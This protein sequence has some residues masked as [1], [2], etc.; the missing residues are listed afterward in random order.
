MNLN[1]GE[2]GRGG[3]KGLSRSGGSWVTGCG[4][5]TA[6]VSFHP[7]QEGYDELGHGWWPWQTCWNQ[8]SFTPGSSETRVPHP[9][10]VKWL[11]G[12]LPPNRK[13]LEELCSF[14][15][16]SASTFPHVHL[17]QR[18]SDSSG[19]SLWKHFPPPALNHV[20]FFSKSCLFLF[21]H[22]FSTLQWT[23]CWLFSHQP[24]TSSWIYGSKRENQNDACFSFCVV[25]EC[26]SQ[27]LLYSW[28]PDI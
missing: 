21:R 16:L 10:Q 14:T 9:P 24:S 5:G 12:F 15:S 7:F 25:E 20:S 1:K 4:P 18:Q 3:W 28:M 8:S 17:N 26:L 13:V 22:W 11:I 19:G 2:A 23:V 6:P 27:S